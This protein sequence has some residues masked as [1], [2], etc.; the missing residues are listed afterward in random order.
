MQI[1]CYANAGFHAPNWER[2]LNRI[3]SLHWA[4]RV[5]IEAFLY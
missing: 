4:A 2:L 3:I 5:V 1:S